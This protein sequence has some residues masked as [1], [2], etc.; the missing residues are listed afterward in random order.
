ML[1]MLKD[2]VNV[3]VQNVFPTSTT[4]NKTQHP[5]LHWPIGTWVADSLG[6]GMMYN[7]VS[8]KPGPTYF[9]GKLSPMRNLYISLSMVLARVGKCLTTPKVLRVFFIKTAS[10]QPLFKAR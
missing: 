2:N 4:E 5:R 6:F 10:K 3:A 8:F 9:A 7:L 1:A